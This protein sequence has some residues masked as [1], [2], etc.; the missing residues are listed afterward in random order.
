MY[1]VLLNGAYGIHV[2][3]SPDLIPRS[4]DPLLLLNEVWYP[5]L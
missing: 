2:H 4:N 1:S 5:V 3:G